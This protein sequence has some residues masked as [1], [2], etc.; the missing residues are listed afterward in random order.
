MNIS[1]SLYSSALLSHENQS[2]APVNPLY[3]TSHLH[4]NTV[5]LSCAPSCMACF[6]NC[7]AFW[8]SAIPS[9]ST[10]VISVSGKTLVKPSVH[11]KKQ[12]CSYKRISG[13][14]DGSI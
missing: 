4:S 3:F 10:A 7:S 1:D 2:I 8:R 12:S 6:I 9:P 5:T 13:L 11:N 14:Q